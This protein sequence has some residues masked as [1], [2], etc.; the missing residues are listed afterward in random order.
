MWIREREKEKRTT[1][2]FALWVEKHNL[3]NSI[4]SFETAYLTCK[5]E[6]F[7]LLIKSINHYLF[8]VKINDTGE[9]MDYICIY[10]ISVY[11]IWGFLVENLRT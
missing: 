7:L 3:Q 10:N 9:S 6:S 5:V 8:Y 1:P 2:F 11:I 4:V